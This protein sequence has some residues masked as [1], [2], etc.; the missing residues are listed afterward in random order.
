M[1]I[2]QSLRLIK[3]AGVMAMTSLGRESIYKYAREGRFP[4]PRKVGRRSTRWIEQ[5]VREW[6]EAQPRA[7]LGAAD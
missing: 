2:E 1:D 3:L 6:I 4:A 7:Q 5:E